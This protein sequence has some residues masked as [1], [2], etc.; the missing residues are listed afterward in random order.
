MS[1][2]IGEVFGFG[3]YGAVLE[4]ALRFAVAG[5]GEAQGGDA[6]AG[7]LFGD[8]DDEGAVLVACDAVSEDGEVGVVGRWVVGRVEALAVAVG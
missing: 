6:A 3:C 4:A 7:E 8:S 1:E 2:E 5:E